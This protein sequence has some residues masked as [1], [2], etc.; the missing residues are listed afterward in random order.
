[1]AWLGK[2]QECNAQTVAANFLSMVVG[3][4][5]LPGALSV[6]MTPNFMVASRIS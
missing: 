2:L 6:T 3:Q 4:Q 5:G 1:M